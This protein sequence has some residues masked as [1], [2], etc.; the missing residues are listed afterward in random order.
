MADYQIESYPDYLARK[1][2]EAEAPV[3][4]KA[5]GVEDKSVKADGEAEGK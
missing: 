1:A 4:K 5:K 3:A 2:A